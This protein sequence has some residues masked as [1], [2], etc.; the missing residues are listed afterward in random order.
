[1]EGDDITAHSDQLAK[2]HERLKALVT[3]EKPLTPEDVHIVAL[4]SSIPPDWIHC[5]SGLMNQEGVK[6]E[7]IVSALK[8][9]SIRRESQGNIISVL[10]TLAKSKP[11]KAKSNQHRPPPSKPNDE[12]KLSRCPLCNTDSHDLNACNNTRQLIS[13]HKAQQKACWEKEQ[14]SNTAPPPAQAGCTSAVTL[15]QS[16]NSYDEDDESDF[17]G[18]EIKVTARNAVAS[19]SS[20]LGPLRSGLTLIPAAQ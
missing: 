3:P 15:G 13:D 18:S 9:E 5:V 20:T 6:S 2:F 8:N 16:S 14:A 7:T 11:F 10:S 19:L 12:K 4:L 1:M 17:S